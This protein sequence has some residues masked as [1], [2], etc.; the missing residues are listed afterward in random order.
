MKG[1]KL[2]LNTKMRTKAKICKVNFLHDIISQFL[3]Y[4]KKASCMHQLHWFVEARPHQQK[5]I[6]VTVMHSKMEPGTQNQVYRN[7]F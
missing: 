7:V 2:C 3:I 1:I 5:F 6:I 4:L